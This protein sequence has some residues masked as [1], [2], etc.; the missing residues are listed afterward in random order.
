MP[1]QD[2]A[3]MLPLMVAQKSY[4]MGEG[5]LAWGRIHPISLVGQILTAPGIVP[6]TQQLHR[7]YSEKND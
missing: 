1:L 7:S 6:G 3:V 5:G 4:T 2:P